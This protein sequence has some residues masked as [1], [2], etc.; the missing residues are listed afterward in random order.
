MSKKLNLEDLKLTSF[1]TGNSV[2]GGRPCS[3]Y[4]L[5]LTHCEDCTYATCTIGEL[6]SLNCSFN[7]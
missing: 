4:C 5:E 3:Y 7:C 2:T 1:V 6:C